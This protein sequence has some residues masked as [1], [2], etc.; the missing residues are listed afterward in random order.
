[1]D[2]YLKVVDDSD[3]FVGFIKDPLLNLANTPDGVLRQSINS[4]FEL[5]MCIKKYQSNLN[6]MLSSN[7]DTAHN[8][9]PLQKLSSRVFKN[10]YSKYKIGQLK[11]TTVP[12][13]KYL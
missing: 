4:N 7:F 6:K 13:T 1:M 5:D 12:V 9:N 10:Y 2:F 8:M 11:V 3:K